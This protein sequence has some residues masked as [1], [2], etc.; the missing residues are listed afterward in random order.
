MQLF[1]AGANTLA[2][3][4]LV[5]AA[6]AVVFVLVAVDRLA[7]SAWLTRVGDAREQPIPFSHKHHVGGV[8]LDCRY[9]HTSVE[10]S[11]F[12]GLPPV[13][14]CMTCHSQLWSEAGLLEPLRRSFATDRGIAWVRVHDLPDF[15]Y[16]NHSIHVRQGIGCTTCHG[17]IDKM[18]LVWQESSLQMSWCLECHRRPE[19][20]VRPRAAV[21]DV[22][23]QSPADQETRGAAL[24]A[25]YGIRKEQLTDC[26]VC[27]R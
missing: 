23:W 10:T 14:T 16:F 8:G 24:V 13:Q 22:G 18:P 1:P 9:C 3:A 2:R 25:L 26:S 19:R 12:A 27:H 6:L 17:P 11:P 4:T 5:G 20:F 7:R 15:V 21:F